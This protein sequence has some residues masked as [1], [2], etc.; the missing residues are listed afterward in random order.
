MCKEEN[1]VMRMQVRRLGINFNS[2][3]ERLPFS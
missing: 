3:R 1:K 2:A